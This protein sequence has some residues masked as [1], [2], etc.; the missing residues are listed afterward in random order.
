MRMR[1]GRPRFYGTQAW[2]RL[3]AQCLARDRVC[4][5]PACGAPATI[6]DHIVPRAMGG[7][8]ALH[9]LRGLCMACHNQRARDGRQPVAAGCDAAGNP[10]PGHWWN[11]S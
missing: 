1:S 5:T 10:H 6:A 2:R 4:T 11:Q 9:N 7:A 3:A 8:D